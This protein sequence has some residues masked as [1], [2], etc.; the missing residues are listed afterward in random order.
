MKLEKIVKNEANYLLYFKEIVVFKKSSNY[1]DDSSSEVKNNSMMFK[2]T[3]QHQ[4]II[5]I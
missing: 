1:K 4:L 5:N 3:T 2:I